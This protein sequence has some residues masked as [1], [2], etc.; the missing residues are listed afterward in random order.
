M[1]L[2][3]R[4]SLGREV[5]ERVITVVPDTARTVL[6][7]EIG[8]VTGIFERYGRRIDDAHAAFLAARFGRDDNGT[9]G[10]A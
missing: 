4:M 9:I 8:P 3:L 1:V 5:I 10:G 6:I 2:S 7:L